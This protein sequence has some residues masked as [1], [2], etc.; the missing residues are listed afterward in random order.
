MFKLIIVVTLVAVALADFRCVDETVAYD[1]PTAILTDGVVEM[2]NCTVENVA[3]WCAGCSLSV[4]NSTFL[5]CPLPGIMVVVEPL[6]D[7]R[8]NTSVDITGVSTVDCGQRDIK[9]IIIMTPPYCAKAWLADFLDKQAR[10]ANE[11]VAF[12]L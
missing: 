8:H 11:S 9:T 3:V 10:F 4:T 7:D 1:D 12:S 5:R 6:A 2:R